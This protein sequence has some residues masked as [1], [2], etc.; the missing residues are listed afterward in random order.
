MFEEFKPGM[1]YVKILWLTKPDDD[2]NGGELTDLEAGKK[3]RER[4]ARLY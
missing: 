3:Y 4:R 2:Y 1:P